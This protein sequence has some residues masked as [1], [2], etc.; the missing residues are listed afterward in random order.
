[1]TEE[2]HPSVADD[3]QR[4]AKMGAPNAEHGQAGADPV[5]PGVEEPPA[6]RPTSPGGGADDEG[7]PTDALGD[8]EAWAMT[9]MPV[10]STR[11]GAET[12]GHAPNSTAQD[13]PVAVEHATPAAS[14]AME[15]GPGRSI[16]A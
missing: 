13:R 10:G 7:D 11:A 6:I 1:M 15:V 16:Q 12:A 4:E 2:L 14:Q 9:G 8:E 3:G 5:V